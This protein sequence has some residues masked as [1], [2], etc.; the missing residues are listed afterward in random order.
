MRPFI[1]VAVAVPLLACSSAQLGGPS[2]TPA[3]TSSSTVIVYG[4]APT[5]CPLSQQPTHVSPFTGPVIGHAPLWALGFVATSPAPVP[6]SRFPA[7]P[8]G[9]PFKVYWVMLA[10]S[11]DAV[12]VTI[13]EMASGASAMIMTSSSATFEAV[14][15]PTHPD[16]V[17][18]TPSSG[19]PATIGYPSSVAISRPGCY[20]IHA[21]W[22]SGEWRSVFAA[23]TNGRT[24]G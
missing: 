5:D 6:Y 12:H 22:R 10:G 8:N 19:E 7:G 13:T 20:E 9:V 2:P 24:P 18:P 4:P 15:D 3:I 1:F 21:S 16:V 11:A 23:G 14:F 17:E